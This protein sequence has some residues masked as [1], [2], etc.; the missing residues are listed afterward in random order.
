MFGGFG[1]VYVDDLK[2]LIDIYGLEIDIVLLW[3]IVENIVSNISNM[4]NKF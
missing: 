2:I 3:V 1:I 4:W